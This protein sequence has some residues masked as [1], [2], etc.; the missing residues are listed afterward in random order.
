[1]RTDDLIAELARD[2]GPVTPLASPRARFLRW[3]AAALVVWAALV[4]FRE[5]RTDLDVMLAR[6]AFVAQALLLLATAALGGVA[7]FVLSVPGA[8]RSRVLRWLPIGAAIAWVAL[9][10]GLLLQ[11]PAP[12]ALVMN[13]R[14]IVSCAIKT[15]TFGAAPALLILLLVRRAAPMERGW[16]AGLAGLGAFALGALGTQIDC[17]INRPSHLLEWHAAPVFLYVAALALAG[18]VLFFRPRFIARVAD[19]PAD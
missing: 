18:R 17:P 14:A 16:T 15:I 12:L 6:P 7:A 5:P 10:V 2:A 3:A 9:I 19:S 13:E 4:V 11:R 1:V 8:E